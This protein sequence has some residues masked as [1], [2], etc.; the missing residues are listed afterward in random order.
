[1]ALRHDQ[2]VAGVRAQSAF[3]HGDMALSCAE[4]LR[5][6]RRCFMHNSWRCRQGGIAPAQFHSKQDTAGE[7]RNQ[8]APGPG[9]T[10][11]G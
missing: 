8:G 4:Q 1:M 3:G 9:E 6:S 2:Q 11:S 10:V 5:R 7:S